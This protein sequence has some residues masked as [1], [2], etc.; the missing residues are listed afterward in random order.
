MN[1]KTG[2]AKAEAE[3]AAIR[4]AHWR[5]KLARGEI[6][7]RVVNDPECFDDD[8]EIQAWLAEPIDEGKTIEIESDQ[9]PTGPGKPGGMG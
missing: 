3:L 4:A 2:V 6:V 1:L 8:P 9:L 7:L 5:T